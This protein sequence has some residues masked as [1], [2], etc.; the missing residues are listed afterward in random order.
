M[1]NLFPH[2]GM[3]VCVAAECERSASGSSANSRKKAVM[4]QVL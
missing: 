1:R 3:C 4:L 2:V